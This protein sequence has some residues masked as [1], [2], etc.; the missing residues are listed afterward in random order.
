MKS[1]KITALL[2]IAFSASIMAADRDKLVRS[3]IINGKVT[4]VVTLSTVEISATKKAKMAKGGIN[5]ANTFEHP[6]GRWVKMAC[7]NNKLVPLVELRT[8][9][10]VALKNTSDNNEPSAIYNATASV[11][12][13]GV[14][15]L[16]NKS[17]RSI[18]FSYVNSNAERINGSLFEKVKNDIGHIFKRIVN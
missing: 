3:E 16:D 5:H 12:S 17:Y 2:I 15:S 6:K 14:Q 8:V 4:P 1:L 9:D 10:V 18:A 13:L 7:I 11:K